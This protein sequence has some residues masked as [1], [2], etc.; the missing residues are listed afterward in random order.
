MSDPVP[1]PATTDA[2]IAGALEQPEEEHFELEKG[3]IVHDGP[4]VLDPPGI[5]VAGLRPPIR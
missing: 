4:R 1:T 2:F 5:T 3:R